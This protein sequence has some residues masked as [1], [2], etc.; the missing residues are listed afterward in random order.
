MAISTAPAY[1]SPQSIR[2]PDIVLDLRRS[3][4]NSARSTASLFQTVSLRPSIKAGVFA[5][6]PA[7]TEISTMSSVPLISNSQREFPQL[8]ALS[9]VSSRT[10]LAD[11][12]R[13]KISSIC[14]SPSSLIY[15]VVHTWASVDTRRLYLLEYPFSQCRVKPVI[16]TTFPRSISAHSSSLA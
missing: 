10:Y 3:R 4:S 16:S 8:V 7:I 2:N 11:T 14:P 15:T 5:P 9:R 12:G 6:P 1:C 13:I